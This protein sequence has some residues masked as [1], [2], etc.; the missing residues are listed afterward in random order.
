MGIELSI[1]AEKSFLHPSLNIQLK[2]IDLIKFYQIASKLNSTVT[3]F[4]K[5]RS[6]KTVNQS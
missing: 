6:K 1:G 5:Y 4:A 2:T 3:S